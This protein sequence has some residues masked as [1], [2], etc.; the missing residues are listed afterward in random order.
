MSQGCSSSVSKALTIA[1]RMERDMFDTFL[2][3]ADVAKLS[4]FLGKTL[5]QGVL[6]SRQYTSTM[7]RWCM[8]L[9]DGCPGGELARLCENSMGHNDSRAYTGAYMATWQHV[10]ANVTKTN[11]ADYMAA[12][13]VL[14]IVA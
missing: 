11:A 5:K 12:T 8:F 6:M 14:W 10:L 13:G 9:L 1:P 2:S 3:Q 7:A 4:K